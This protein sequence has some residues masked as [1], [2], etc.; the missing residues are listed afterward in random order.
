MMA[1]IINLRLA[2]KAR[3]R[4]DEQN[5]ADANRRLHGRTR[6]EKLRD[7]AEAERLSKHLDQSK[8]NRETGGKITD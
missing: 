3:A 2:R 6:S 4:R 5:A 7:K 8:L 1:E